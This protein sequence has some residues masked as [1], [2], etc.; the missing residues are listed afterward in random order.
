M[1]AKYEYL[2][3]V[4][5]G[6]WNEWNVAVHGDQYVPYRWFD[7]AEERQMELDRLRGLANQLGTFDAV[8]V[9]SFSEGYLTR[10]KHVLYSCVKIGDVIMG[11]ENDLGYGFFS[12]EDLLDNT[13]GNMIDYFLRTRWDQCVTLPDDAELLF[14][15]LILKP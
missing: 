9:H 11:V 8:I 6:F 15:T 12:R 14:S 10:Q 2:L 13:P 7:T 1:K 5:G 4:W 3:H